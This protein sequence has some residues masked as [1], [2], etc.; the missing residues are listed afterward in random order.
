MWC[1]TSD[2]L[3]PIAAPVAW[4]HSL[5]PVN[6]ECTIIVY[7]AFDCAWSRQLWRVTRDVFPALD[8]QPRLIFRHLPGRTAW[9]MAAARLTEHASAH[10]LF[11]PAHDQIVAS[12]SSMAELETLRDS[13]GVPP[14]TAEPGWDRIAEHARVV[15]TPAI[16]IDQKRYTGAAEARLA[17]FAAA[18]MWSRHQLPSR[19]R[20]RDAETSTGRALVRDL[21]LAVGP[22]HLAL[23][24][25]AEASDGA[26]RMRLEHARDQARMLGARLD[27]FQGRRHTVSNDLN[28][29]L[30]HAIDVHQPGGHG[31]LVAAASAPLPGHWDPVAIDDIVAHAVAL[32][33]ERAGGTCD[34]C[35]SALGPFARIT[36]EGAGLE[37]SNLAV[38]QSIANAVAG[39]AFLEAATLCVDLPRP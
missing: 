13:L 15:S 14:S 2:D 11:W 28:A 31:P 4:D 9:S 30:Q 33:R 1:T 37:A 27:A 34:V 18:L 5:G 21:A 12:S 26:T 25:I 20:Q 23:D 16:Y 39:R 29:L 17:A 8:P 35:T 22:I 7:G 3:P 6:A 36:V 38:F 10:G 32:T 24:E 19:R